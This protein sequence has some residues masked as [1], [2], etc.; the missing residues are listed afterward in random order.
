MKR[1]NTPNSTQK[2]ERTIAWKINLNLIM[3]LI[4]ALTIMIT[5]SCLLASD[6]I[7]QLNKKLLEVQT[8][9]AVSMVDDFFSGKTA[10]LS[11]YEQD[12]TL[13]DYFKGISGLEDISSYEGL[14]EIQQELSYIS[15]R[16]DQEDILQVWVAD[17]ESD[18][19]LL[20]SGEIGKSDISNTRWY[21]LAV[22]S[23]DPVV[24]DPYVDS[25]NGANVISVVTP[26]YDEET[27]EILGF[28]GIDVS[29]DTLSSLMSSI[30][31][32]DKGFIEL[33]SNDS[34]YIYS[35]DPTAVGKNVDTLDI[36]DDYKS[37]VYANYN[38][39][40]DFSYMGT[41][42]TSIF[43]NSQTTGWLTIAT[44]PVSE[45]NAVRDRL[46]FVLAALSVFVIAILVL[47]ILSITRKTMRPL[48]QISSSMEEFAHGK[49][50]VEFKIHSKD[51]IGRM[52]ESA[53]STI[54]VL[55]EMIRD[56][57]DILSE[58]SNGNLTSEVN[59]C[60]V[61]DFKGIKDAL[62]QIIESLNATL[63][64]INSSAE[65]V[66]IGAEQVSDSAQ[67]LAQGAS[68]QA[69]TVEELASGINEISLQITSNAENSD[70]AN[71]RAASVRSEAVESNRRMQEMLKAMGEIKDST[72]KI[73]S[74]LKAIEDIAS[75][76]NLLALNASVEAARA[77]E[78]GRG[79]SVVAAEVRSLAAKSAKAA[80]DTTLLIDGS[81]KAVES[82][83]AIADDTAKSL[84]H[85][86]GGV[87]DVA[88]KLIEISRASK[89]QADSVDQVTKGIQQISMVVQGNSATAEEC[90]AAS[91][92]LSAQA[93]LLKQLIERFQI[94]E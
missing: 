36:A 61:G 82:G 90:A 77:G 7:M 94:K 44:L 48:A 74:I 22:N 78:A 53:G 62:E 19:Y 84:E 24:S 20:S 37:K 81:L 87:G 42:Y 30:T 86:V 17:E 39:T 80:K 85:V 27:T 92:E 34:V 46:I 15:G 45:M 43:S 2:K 29:L 3:V 9:Y 76:T 58:I 25:A 21:Q 60:Y 4:P 10:A 70:A 68:E 69:G 56:T 66:S 33:L 52:A 14:P 59:G 54:S 83:T 18:C 23:S 51:E 13:S 11:M 55:K 28:L 12:S 32:G 57:S 91:E 6:A 65:Q 89:E 88:D 5:L 73:G 49:L 1:K 35:N 75:Q 63:K 26:V 47:I 8:E 50:D 71:Q 93:V 79:F 31:V 41:Q 67:N 40:E 38:G 64:Q 72:K 16:M